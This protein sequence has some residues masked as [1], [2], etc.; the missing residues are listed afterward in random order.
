MGKQSV[1]YMGTWELQRRKEQNQQQKLDRLRELEKSV[2]Y[3][4][5]YNDSRAVPVRKE[6][7]DEQRLQT[8]FRKSLIAAINKLLPLP[9]VADKETVGNRYFRLPDLVASLSLLGINDAEAVARKFFQLQTNKKGQIN[10]NTKLPLHAI[11]CFTVPDTISKPRD[12]QSKRNKSPKVGAADVVR[13]RVDATN[14]DINKMLRADNNKESSNLICHFLQA[15]KFKGVQNG[16]SGASAKSDEEREHAKYIKSLQK[17]IVEKARDIFKQKFFMDGKAEVIMD[18]F[19]KYDVDQSHALDKFEF[20]N[21]LAALKLGLTEDEV[22]ALIKAFDDDNSGEIEYREFYKAM[23]KSDARNAGK[24]ELHEYKM[25]LTFGE[26]TYA[27][28]TRRLKKQKRDQAREMFRPVDKEHAALALQ[29]ALKTRRISKSRLVNFFLKND[30]DG[31]GDLDIDEFKVAMNKDLKLGLGEQHLDA[32]IHLLDHNHDGEI[33]YHEL[34]DILKPRV[35][36][37]PKRKKLTA[38]Q[39]NQYPYIRQRTWYGPKFHSII[40]L[41]KNGHTQRS[42]ASLPK[43]TAKR[44]PSKRRT[45]S[46]TMKQTVHT[47]GISK[48]AGD[49]FFSGFMG[50]NKTLQ[51]RK[52]LLKLSKSKERMSLVANKSKGQNSRNHV[53]SAPILGVGELSSPVEEYLRSFAEHNVDQRR[54][55]KESL[56]QRPNTAFN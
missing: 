4:Q 39:I 21:A 50:K 40:K 45:L 54:E 52:K 34:A 51:R 55:S 36:L 5:N 16:D 32:L 11:N 23:I 17:V 12:F 1:K 30:K 18:L 26:A 2:A 31:S 27:R 3:R 6:K 46:D 10:M 37:K 14:I 8:S 42:Y 28:E 35:K 43:L 20:S 56:I 7:S 38:K 47:R 48:V 25:E 41:S 15:Q 44:H 9:L 33:S 19:M 53:S 24:K 22:E 49:K 13:R 29:L